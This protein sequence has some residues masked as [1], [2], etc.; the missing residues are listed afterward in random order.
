VLLPFDRFYSELVLISLVI[1]TIIHLKKSRL[2]SIPAIILLFSSI[3]LLTI[4]GT[5]YTRD[6][7][8]AFKDWEKQL[9]LILF[10][11]IFSINSIE[12]N[13]YKLNLLKSFS[14]TNLLTG[15]YLYFD[16]F[17]II[18][19]N[20]LPFSSILDPIFTSHN[21]SQA[22]GLH[23]TYFSLYISIS[24]IT[25]I[26]LSIIS[27][28]RNFYLAA[29]IILFLVLLQLQ[30]RSVLI[31][32]LLIINFL[33][34]FNLLKRNVSKKLIAVFPALSLIIIFFTFQ[35]HNFK[36]RFVS[37]LKSDISQN[38]G[39]I[40][41]V[42]PRAARWACALELIKASPLIG[43][44]S[45][46]EVQ[47]LKEKYFQKGYYTSFLNELNAHN[48]YLSLTIQFGFAGLAIYLF[49]LIIAFA[50]GLSRK[51]IL[52][53]GF[54]ALIATV[55]LSENILDTNKGIFFFSFF[56]SFL[57]WPLNEFEIAP[58]NYS[59]SPFE[60]G[61]ISSVL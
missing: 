32:S 10:P 28:K 21:F 17:R 41:D 14:I 51:D 48:E 38:D 5:L 2:R 59:S 20:H 22:I 57:S 45:G 29:S 40:H 42:E 47:L 25:M 35:N 44:G 1:H 26:Y 33:I 54:I 18:I 50:N 11:L 58:T 39:K 55:S 19:Y 52:L 56:L 34:P 6:P 7:Q 61:I 16:A 27:M 31:A 60:D 12:L 3:W 46:S 8:Q 23:A 43:Y 24:L 30:S 13:K 36:K 15:I 53:T 37:D 49:L 9:A 4:F